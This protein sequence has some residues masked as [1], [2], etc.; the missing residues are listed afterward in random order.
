MSF[1]CS[2]VDTI[3][4]CFVVAMMVEAIQIR[5]MTAFIPPGSALKA[6]AQLPDALS[7]SRSLVENG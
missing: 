7:L 4:A 5:R 3:G 1:P 2:P 6:S